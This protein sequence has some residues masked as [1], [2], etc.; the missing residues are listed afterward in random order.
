MA[1]KRGN[2]E[3]SIIQRKDGRWQATI[4]AGHDANGKPK[5][6]AFYGK[7]RK[8]AVSKMNEALQSLQQ[9]NY[10]EPSRI[11][12]GE[13]IQRWLDDYAKPKTRQT[14]W[15]SYE[16]IIKTHII[17]DLGKIPLAKL[18]ASDLQRFYNQKL[19]SGRIKDN[20][21]LS[22]RYVR[23]MHTLIKK[24]LDQALKENLIS[25]NMANATQPPTVKTK[26]MT[27]LTED[28]LVTLIDVARQDRL[29][30]AFILDIATGLRRGELL[31]LK[32]DVLDLSKGNIVVKRQLLS[33]KGGSVIEEDIKTKSS[34][35]NIPIPANIVKELKVHK[36]RQA[37]EKLA[38]GEAYQNNN[39]V[40][41][42]EDGSLLDPREF[43]KRFQ[44]LLKKAELPKIRLHDI[45]HSHASL[46]LA[47]GV[48]PKVIQE[49]LG[50][51]SITITLDL[52]SHLAPGMQEAASNMID[53]LF[54][55]EKDPIQA[56]HEQGK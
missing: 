29:A 39:L 55:K 36:A 52:Y 17:P 28:Q 46:L 20:S 10:V 5:R 27:C 44:G 7:T 40:F 35:R 13:W 11:T 48:S 50:H 38:F 54:H 8:E 18:Q 32:W 21:G 3:G 43:T 19:Q 14:T 15:E 51:S 6:R 1:K 16:V 26:K 41:C 2:G 22:T 42:K 30:A 37:K 45:R 49:R 31:G 24:S 34:E 9:G 47:K 23:Y 25:K 53:D 4:T 33:V 56:E 12:F